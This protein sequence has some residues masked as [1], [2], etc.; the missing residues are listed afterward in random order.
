MEW[1]LYSKCNIPSTFESFVID[2]DKSSKNIFIYILA[3]L[4]KMFEY[5]N[6]PE[7][8][9]IHVLDRYLMLNGIACITEVDGLLYA[10]SGNLGDVQDIYYRPTKFIVS[11][12]HLGS[13]G[14]FK[15]VTV[16]GDEPHDGVLMRND[17][18]W[19]GL[20]PLIGR[21]SYLM[22]ENFITIRSADIMLRILALLTAPDDDT[23]RSA[24]MYIE[25]LIKGEIS[26]I[27][28][29]RFLDGINMQSPPSNN[30]SYLTQF[31]ELHQYLLGGLYNELGLKANYNMKREAIGT[32]EST[33]DD[34]VILPLCEN[35]LMCRR[36]D[37]A[38]VNEMFGTNIEV[39]F[40]S[41]W[42][43]KRLL[44]SI[45]ILDKASQLVSSSNI[46]PCNV[47][48]GNTPKNNIPEDNIPE[49]NISENNISDDNI[50]ENNI[51][52]DNTSEDNN[53]EDNIPDDN[54]TD[55][56]NRDDLDNI[57][58]EL[59]KDISD[60]ITEKEIND[61]NKCESEESNT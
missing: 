18:E 55:N 56:K 34:D 51:P 59:V 12:P 40:S 1:D 6:V 5:K 8:L 60:F 19:M 3:R 16:L 26:C 23:K 42:K 41:A 21:Y 48:E 10:F 33:M 44:S 46:S 45:E 47:T 52:E 31:I 29:N 17:T 27:G 36:E 2:K 28:E 13:S 37:F 14:F 38:K 53:S 61:E 4:Q 43:S 9:D 30:G 15:N 49:D 32:G 39:D 35:M 54:I 25:K 24:D 50:S 20:M 57:V 7:T 58:N 11:N 22:A